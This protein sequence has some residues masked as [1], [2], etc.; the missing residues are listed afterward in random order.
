MGRKC[1]KMAR[2][3]KSTVLFFIV[4]I[5]FSSS[6]ELYACGGKDVVLSEDPEKGA[7]FSAYGNGQQM[8]FDDAGFL[9]KDK[10]EA[11]ISP[12]LAQAIVDRFV[13]QKIPSLTRPFTFR[14]LEYVHGKLIYQFTSEDP[15]P[16]YNGK[17]HLGPVN[18]I[19]DH[20]VLDVDAKTGNIYVASGCGAA[21]GQ[22]LYRYRASDF[23]VDEFNSQ[24][25]FI[26]NNTNFIAR[27]TGN[28]IRIDGE[29][30][31][32]EWDETGHKY[33]YIGTYSEHAPSEQHLKPYYYA[34][35][36]TQ[37]DEENIYFAVKTDTPYWIGL[38]FKEDP[39]LGMLGSYRDAKV[40][41]SDGEVT[42]RHFAKRPDKT[43][44][45]KKDN[46]D[47]ILSMAS[48]Q[49]DFYTY[50]FAFPLRTDDS[51]DIVF[52]KGKAYNM[53]LSVGNTLEH[54]GIFTLDKA[55]KNHAHSKNNKEHSD[56]WASK[57]EIIRIGD[58]ADR[59]IWGNPVKTVFASY[60]SGFDSSKKQNHFHYAES[61]IAGFGKRDLFSS[62]V[63]WLSV[64]V[65]LSGVGI[66]IARFRKTPHRPIDHEGENGADLLRF[67]LFR[68]FIAWKNFRNIFIIPTMSI[69][70]LIIILGFLDV[71][72]GKRNIATI[73]TWTLWW[74]L[75]IVS[76]VIAGRFWCMMC[77]FAALGD[78]A[79]KVVSLN[80]SLPR[81]LQNM[82]FQAGAFVLL[83]LA[84]ALF[85]FDS[86]PMITSF[87]IVTITLSAVV[88]SIIYKRRSFCR[89]LCPIGA[90]IGIYST[91]SPI[92]LRASKK[93]LCTTHLDKT[94]GTACP[95]LEDPY[96][97]DDNVYCNFCMKC[98]TAC[99]NNNLGFRLRTFG[100]DIY[101]SIRKS[102]M[103]ALASLFLLGIVIFET[104]AMTASWP[105]V[106]EYVGYTTGI[107]T[108]WMVYILL[109]SFIVLIPVGSFFLFCYLLRLWI[110]RG[111]IQTMSLV[112][113]FAFVLIPLGISLHLA[114]NMQHLFI[115]GPI[116]VPATL[117]LL[118]SIGIGTSFLV[119]W[120]V[121]PL[122]GLE[123]I[124]F[125]Q[126]TIILLGL[127]FTLYILYRMLRRFNK[128]LSLTYKTALVMSFYI[129][130]VVLSS[131][132]MLGLPMNGR[133]VH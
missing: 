27:N 92:E 101:D 124:F 133:H 123:P 132:Y 105:Q 2:R 96:E 111:N 64:L 102:P 88:F 57:E 21:P 15:L 94:C 60:V 114:H 33:F 19:V 53:L 116:A 129:I 50:E 130:V 59:D 126:M 106:E 109:F 17:Y 62:F 47:H 113:E 58:P 10:T 63:S 95:M 128:P 7:S 86:K 54:H 87:V 82:G 120:N 104:F 29:I 23:Q 16:D 5:L 75:I 84:F 99:P 3:L 108:P 52:E 69:F 121:S 127:V 115:E 117:R 55:H 41:K 45:L 9:L 97:M 73:Y 100:K 48:R 8:F 76:F 79:Q 103:E 38:M 71:Q 12:S 49:N 125:I 61:P 28:E 30:N 80:R 14:K 51:Q 11:R 131:V 39:N 36:W 22:L 13:Q 40:M 77:P 90:V 89:N 25:E 83:T 37:I 72:D 107:S 122:I 35:V 93:D 18:F 119:N 67:R 81:W 20:P 70:L 44:H 42:D 43:F 34:E 46:V 68:R 112:T 74:S 78:L 85:A 26:S 110:G 6:G 24:R 4:L 1:E 56:V 98:Q 65:G 32:G 91:V 118:Q 66:I 31:P